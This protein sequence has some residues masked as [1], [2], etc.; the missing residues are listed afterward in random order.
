MIVIEASA[1]VSALVGDPATPELLAVLADEELHAPALLDFEVASALRGH[2]FGGL[3]DQARVDEALEDFTALRIERHQM[4]HALAH[5]L[6]LRDNFTAYDAAYVVL[7]LV[8][9]APLITSDT[10]MQEARRLGVDVQLIPA[11]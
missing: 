7:A 11:S 6:D 10:K 9:E 8:T 3:L 5:I 4:T 2:L 1:M